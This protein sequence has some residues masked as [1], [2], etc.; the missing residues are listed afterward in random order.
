V[1]V[2]RFLVDT[3]AWARYP[4]PTVGAR[5]DEL[6]AAG[7]AA[8]CGL[9]ELQLLDTVRDW[10]TYTTLA[11]LRRAAFPL[12]EVN[13]ADL[14]RALEVQSLLVEHGEVAVAWPALVVAAVAERHGVTV[15][16]CDP[17]FDVIVKITGQGVEGIGAAEFPAG[18]R[19]ELPT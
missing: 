4:D 3:S 9:V 10:Q 1:P 17:C 7:V 19:P 2:I 8:T 12:L 5:L 16:C 11:G 18:H 14:Q 13:D 6:S 15:L